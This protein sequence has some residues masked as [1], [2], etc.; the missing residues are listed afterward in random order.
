MVK[1]RLGMGVKTRIF[2]W[3]LSIG[4]FAIGAFAIGAPANASEDLLKNH[5]MGCHVPEQ[6]NPLKLS[7]ISHQRKTPE[8]WLMTIA[9]MQV[10]HGLQV[11]DENRRALVK[12]LD[13][14][15]EQ[16][17]VSLNIPTGIP[18]VYELDEDLKPLAHYYL[19]DQ[20]A[21]K[22]AADSV[23]NQAQGK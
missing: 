6:M 18:L 4:A 11:S 1:K 16:D 12:H 15:S 3:V 14:V 8:G 9:R 17:I 10:V 7:R 20:E 5:C 23:A 2:S 13:G 21:A 22:K 19:G